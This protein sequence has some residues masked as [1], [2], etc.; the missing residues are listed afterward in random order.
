MPERFQ[1]LV[2]ANPDFTSNSKQVKYKVN[3]FLSKHNCVRLSFYHFLY[4]IFI[5]INLTYYFFARKNSM[6]DY[7][8]C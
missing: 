3:M 7:I 2:F 6:F 5:G 4:A 1:I 8:Y